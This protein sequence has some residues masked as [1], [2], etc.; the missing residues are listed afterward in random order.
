MMIPVLALLLAAGSVQQ[1]TD[2]TFAVQPG[3]Q[4]QLEV[5][6]GSATIRTWD[7]SAMRVVAVY[8]RPAQLHVRQRGGAVHVEAERPNSLTGPAGLRVRYEITVP[9]NFGVGI[10]G[11]SA[12]VDIEGVEGN[13]VVENVE[14][15]IRVAG[16]TGNVRTTSVSGAV[17]IDN[18]RGDVSVQ[19]V[20]QGARL[21][22]VR[23]ALDIEAVNGGIRMERIESRSVQASTLNGAVDYSGSIHDGGRY[24]LGTHNGRITLAV[25]ENTNATLAITTRVGQVDTAFPVRVGSA[26]DGSVTVTLG[27]GSARVELESYNGSVRLVRP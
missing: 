11:M 4:L 3:A 5:F 6:A 22:G 18:V 23:G 27:S 19:T 14:G 9:R 10:E 2:T 20:N 1:Q 7:R 8:N 17:T 21:T 16:V 15:A 12:D 13:I 25:P 24:Y 26:R